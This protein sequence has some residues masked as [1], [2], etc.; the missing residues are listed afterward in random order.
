PAVAVGVCGTAICAHALDGVRPRRPHRSAGRLCAAEADVWRIG[1]ISSALAALRDCPT[2]RKIRLLK[3][4]FWNQVI[5]SSHVAPQYFLFMV[6]VHLKQQTP[7]G[8][9]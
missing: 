5:D 3:I 7:N 1:V 9:L 8:F 2:A 4:F 6:A